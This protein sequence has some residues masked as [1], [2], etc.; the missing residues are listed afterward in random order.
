[1]SSNISSHAAPATTTPLQILSSAPVPDS[2]I[3]IIDSAEIAEPTEPD[4]IPVT[5]KPLSAKAL[6]KQPAKP[7]QV[8]QASNSRQASQALSIAETSEST[9]PDPAPGGSWHAKPWQAEGLLYYIKIVEELVRN[10]FIT[11][12]N[13]KKL[14]GQAGVRDVFLREERDMNLSRSANVEAILGQSRGKIEEEECEG[15]AEGMGLFTFCVTVEGMF[16]GSC[17]NCHFGS[18]ASGCSF[19]QD[20]GEKKPKRSAKKAGIVCEGEESVAR[21]AKGRKRRQVDLPERFRKVGTLLSCL[22]EEFMNI[23]DELEE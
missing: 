16:K 19:R 5:S 18:K 20:E 8:R 22:A 15:C 17:T 2:E 9:T 3:M 21:G 14:A 4:T 23:A 13:C 6:G 10:G 11:T 7:N 1:M 12:G